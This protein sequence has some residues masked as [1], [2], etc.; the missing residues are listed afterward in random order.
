ML[1]N[2]F[3]NKVC[4]VCGKRRGQH[5]HVNSGATDLSC[6]QRKDYPDSPL[7]EWNGSYM[8]RGKVGNSS[9]PNMAFKMK[10]RN[11]NG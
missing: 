7:F 5:Y 10:K 6:R 2:H 9:N 3:N 1:D 11:R 4:S 8:T